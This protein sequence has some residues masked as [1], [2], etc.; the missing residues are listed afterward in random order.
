MNNPLPPAS[1]PPPQRPEIGLRVASWDAPPAPSGWPA[2]L[3]LL[4]R[5]MA[6]ARRRAAALLV[7]PE[8][9]GAGHLGPGLDAA[10]E[11][12]DGPLAQALATLCRAHRIGL[13]VGYLEACSGRVHSACLVLGAAGE[14]IANYR[15]VHRAPHDP[16]WLTE[17]QWLTVV[18]WRDRRLGLMIGADLDHPETARAL[19][20][21]G[22]D[23]LIV[24]DR[25]DARREGRAT[26]LAARRLE[27]GIDVVAAPADAVPDAAGLV[28]TDLDAVDAGRAGRVRRLA[29]RRPRLY[30]VLGAVDEL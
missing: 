12:S 16:A 22:A 14:A 30:R 26:L 1:E 8:T 29:A 18:P 9:G 6:E 15:R 19:V 24:Q 3:P 27:N 23:L 21:A 10:A 11:A 20:L 17:G 7:T 4:D 25:A 13:V 5:A 2:R 28:L